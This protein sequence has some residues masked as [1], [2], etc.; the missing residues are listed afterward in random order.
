MCV[1]SVTLRVGKPWTPYWVQMGWFLASEQ[2]MAATPTAPCHPVERTVQ[3]VCKCRYI[4]LKELLLLLVHVHA[5]STC[6][7]T[8]QLN[9]SSI[10]G[11][12]VL[13][14]LECTRMHQML[15][16]ICNISSSVWGDIFMHDICYTKFK[17][18]QY[19]LKRFN[20]TI[21]GSCLWLLWYNQ[22]V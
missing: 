22:N 15:K 10:Y 7:C 19:S 14:I 1:K 2:S 21:T 8:L 17:V 13:L 6:A 4:K 11:V 12:H 5:S 20:K 3:L 9:W 16:V 18:E